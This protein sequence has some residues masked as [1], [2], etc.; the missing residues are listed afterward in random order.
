[1]SINKCSI[2]GKAG[3]YN[4]FHEQSARFD[5]FLYA[6]F[7][8]KSVAVLNNI[9]YACNVRCQSCPLQ[10]IEQLAGIKGWTRAATHLRK[11]N[12][13]VYEHYGILY[14]NRTVLF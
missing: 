5:N 9:L 10:S 12:M 3:S 4:T 1:M 8:K 14:S 11:K 13:I 2:F 7:E 6:M